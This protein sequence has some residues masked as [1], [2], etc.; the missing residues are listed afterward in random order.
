MSRIES[1]YRVEDAI[2]RLGDVARTS[3]TSTF[4][5]KQDVAQ[6]TGSKTFNDIKRRIDRIDRGQP[7]ATIAG[8]YLPR[9]NGIVQNMF[10][11]KYVNAEYED[12]LGDE[13]NFNVPLDLNR[14]VNRPG[15]QFDAIQMNELAFLY[16]N[17]E[18]NLNTGR[19][20]GQAFTIQFN[21]MDIFPAQVYN[22]ASAQLQQRLAKCHPQEYAKTTPIDYWKDYSVEG[23]PQ[24]ISAMKN[25]SSVFIVGTSLTDNCIPDESKCSMLTTMRARGMCKVNNYW[26]SNVKPGAHL[27]AVIRKFE[28][29]DYCFDYL[30]GRQVLTDYTGKRIASSNDCDVNPLLPY[31]L[32]F[33]CLPDG[34]PVPTEYTRYYDEPGHL[35]TDAHVIRIGTVT[36]VP[37]G[38]VYRD[39]SSR[40]KPYYGK[41]PVCAMSNYTMTKDY[42]PVSHSPI[43]IKLKPDDGIMP[44]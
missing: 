26:G 22:Y 3:G 18:G 37:I 36:E 20:E 5:T 4:I 24:H 33:F 44:L 39:V 32:A 41:L 23:V 21:P 35:R 34:G 31:Q 10:N 12:G 1:G 27:Y 42:T 2:G 6:R 38:H 30:L 28:Q 40:L 25:R 17:N 11:T 14:Q 19:L 9:D 16:K 8:R 29:S 7:L 43:T 13:N 15:P